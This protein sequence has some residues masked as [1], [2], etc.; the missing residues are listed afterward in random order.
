MIETEAW[1][2]DD[3]RSTS[4]AGVF[5]AES[6]AGDVVALCGLEASDPSASVTVYF[7]IAPEERLALREPW[8]AYASERVE[9]I[10]GEA[11]VRYAVWIRG[12]TA[13]AKGG[14]PWPGCRAY[15]TVGGRPIDRC[16]SVR[17]HDP[18]VRPR[19]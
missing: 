2:R 7:P 19:A 9:E 8:T 13:D 14:T 12:A 18:G 3:W 16:A 4:N 5:V 1:L 15:G 6:A 11:A 17:P 10:A